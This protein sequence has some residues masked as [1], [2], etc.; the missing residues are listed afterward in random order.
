M[1]ATSPRAHSSVF[2]APSAARMEEARLTLYGWLAARTQTCP[3]KRGSARSSQ[4][5]SPSGGP[6]CL[7]YMTTRARLDT[8]NH[9]PSGSRSAAGTRLSSTGERIGRSTPAAL[10]RASRAASTVMSTSAGLLA[11]SLRMRSMS[12]SASPSISRTRMPVSRVKVS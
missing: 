10:A 1:F 11:P 3:R 7:S 12:W 4:R 8:P 9:V 2:S 5:A 6:F